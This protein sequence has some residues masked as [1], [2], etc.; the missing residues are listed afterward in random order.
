MEESTNEAKSSEKSLAKKAKKPKK[1]APKSKPKKTEKTNVAR[2]GY[3]RHSIEKALRIPRAILE[4]NAGRSCTQLEAAKFIGLQS[5]AGPFQ[6]EISSSKKYGFLE[7]PE[8]GK[9]Q[10]TSL[11]K[12]IIRPQSANDAISGFR[13]GIENAKEF[14][15][16]Y[17]HYRGENLPDDVFLV[18][19]LVETFNVPNDQIQ[20]FK[21]VFLESLETANL[22]EHHGD[23]LRLV[24]DSTEPILSPERMKTLG[25][26]ITVSTSDVC[27]V[28]QPFSSPLGE[29]YDKIYKPAIEKAGLKPL[30]ADAELFGTGKIIDQVWR[31]ITGA[32]VLVAELTSRNPN[33]FYEL[34]LAH[35]LQKPVVLISANESDVPFDLRH[36][37]V[38]YYDVTDPFWGTKLL[39]KVTENILSAIRNP[40]E[41]LFKP[42]DQ[43]GA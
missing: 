35:A 26:G 6:L 18:N 4:Q 27:F 8:P 40:E 2:N 3:P 1:I 19:S 9:I 39:E 11:A 34:G 7:S 15:D 42:A 24:D 28:M 38:I 43:R 30:R 36:I 14:R 29:Y 31:G 32:K 33:V 12:Q 22:I 5:V 21:Q 13:K 10:P 41:A 20:D 16:V 23:K 37:R 17:L 25:K